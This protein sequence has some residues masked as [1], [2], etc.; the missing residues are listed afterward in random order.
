MSPGSRNRDSKAESGES[1]DKESVLRLRAAVIQSIRSFFIKR[2][3]IEV[4][5]PNLIHAPAPEIHIEAVSS[6]EGF[7]HTSP[8]LQMKRLLSSGYSMIFQICKCF[9][10]G[11]RGDLHLPEFTLLEWYRAGA[12]YMNLMEECE[13]MIRFAANETGQGNSIR[14]MD[15]IIDLNGPWRRITVEDAFSLYSPISLQEALDL[16]RF[17]EIMVL[18]IEPAL[19]KTRPVF[20]YDYPASL[21]GLARLKKGALNVAERF[22][23]YIGGL[24]LANAF[25][26]LTDVKEQERRFR[27]DL[28]IRKKTGKKEYPFPQKFID[29]LHMMPDSAGIAFGIDRLVMLFSNKGRIDD[30]VSFT[31][32]SI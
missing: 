6:G 17:D 22:E 19:D 4:E 25:T 24:E 32:E 18:E 27:R 26:E 16:E 13:E 29:D 20:L 7:M 3:Y 28:N 2:G 12:D 5:T 9:R 10:E 15:N 14:Y 21:A 30:V 23:L 1:S 11:E 8:E 31:P